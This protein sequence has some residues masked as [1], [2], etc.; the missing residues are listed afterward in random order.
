MEEEVILYKAKFKYS[1]E[2]A[3]EL[4]LEKGENTIMHNLKYILIR[5]KI[6]ININAFEYNTNIFI[7]TYGIKTSTSFSVNGMCIQGCVLKF[8]NKINP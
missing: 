1:P 4:V 8:S 3:D 6:H 2:H 5:L 7:S